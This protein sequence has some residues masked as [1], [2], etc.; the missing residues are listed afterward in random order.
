MQVLRVQASSGVMMLRLAR[1][2][3][4]AGEGGITRLLLPERDA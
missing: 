3:G 1:H 2:C 4:V